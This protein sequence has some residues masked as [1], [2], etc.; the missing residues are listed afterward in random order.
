MIKWGLLPFIGCKFFFISNI[1]QSINIFLLKLKS[2]H[3]SIYLTKYCDINKHKSPS[4]IW[5]HLISITLYIAAG[6]KPLCVDIYIYIYIYIYTKLLL[7]CACLCVKNE[8]YYSY[9][10]YKNTNINTKITCKELQR[11]NS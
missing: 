3:K 5:H 6:L 10:T 11:N 7:L 1:I 2:F 8:S 9:H 4:M